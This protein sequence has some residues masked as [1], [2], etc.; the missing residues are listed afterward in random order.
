MESQRETS[1]W[2]RPKK[3]R[4]EREGSRKLVI[5]AIPDHRGH[6]PLKLP[7]FFHSQNQNDTW[8]HTPVHHK[9][10][11][12]NTTTHNRSIRT[13]PNALPGESWES[14]SA[15]ASV[16]CLKGEWDDIPS[17]QSHPRQAALWSH[18][19]P[20]QW[21]SGL[22]QPPQERENR[23]RRSCGLQWAGRPAS[24]VIFHSSQWR[25]RRESD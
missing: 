3:P 15:S 1:V 8:L 17:R 16:S 21:L 4:R 2:R 12:T 5:M 23:A 6:F 20:D 9:H 7:P 22:N 10:T 18:H 24:A 11:E 25:G 19:S 14:S 13:C